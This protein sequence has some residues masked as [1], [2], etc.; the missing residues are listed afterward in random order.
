MREKSERFYIENRTQINLVVDWNAIH[1]ATKT[2][3]VSQS[4]L[5]FCFV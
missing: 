2:S 3:M 4:F 5:Y 1:C